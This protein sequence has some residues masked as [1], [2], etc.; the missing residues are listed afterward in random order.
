M[1][2]GTC[3]ATVHGVTKSLTRLSAHV[4]MCTHT[5]INTP[6]FRDFFLRGEDKCWAT[7]CMVESGS[8]PCFPSCQGPF[9]MGQCLGSSLWSPW[10]CCPQLCQ[11]S[12]CSHTGT[13]TIQVHSC[14]CVYTH[15]HT[16]MQPSAHKAQKGLA[17][18]WWV[19]C[20]VHL[21][22]SDSVSVCLWV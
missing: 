6:F 19:G 4:H 16:H 17:V 9:L 15:T 10:G 5:H 3:W 18:L 8:T 1:G 7:T 2:R 21:S 22:G 14:L 12:W 20:T 11:H 13:L